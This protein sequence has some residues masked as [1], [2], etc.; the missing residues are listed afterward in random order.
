MPFPRTSGVLLH[1]T[2]L[3]GPYGIGDLGE[4]AFK[5]VEFLAESGQTLW[6]LLP[7]GFTGADSGNSPYQSMS[8][9]AGSPLLI[10][11]DRLAEQK[12]LAAADLKSAPSFSTQSIDYGPVTD[13]KMGLL[14]RAFQS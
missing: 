1:P 7:L 4:A 6:Q 14:H 5:W 12:L 9:F 2:S 3:P 10:S 11:L 8:A 13:W